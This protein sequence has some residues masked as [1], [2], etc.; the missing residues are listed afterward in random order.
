MFVTGLA[1]NAVFFA[2]G[3]DATFNLASAYGVGFLEFSICKNV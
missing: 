3:G 2:M 1:T